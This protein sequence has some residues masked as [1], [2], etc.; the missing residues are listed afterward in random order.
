M[1]TMVDII[2]LLLLFILF[3]WVGTIEKKID[4]ISDDVIDLM[5]DSE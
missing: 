1:G 3:C 5:D 4:L 2:T